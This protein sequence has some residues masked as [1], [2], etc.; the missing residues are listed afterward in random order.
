[1]QTM[2]HSI[3][4]IIIINDDVNVDIICEVIVC[5][6]QL[7]NANKIKIT[8]IKSNLLATAR[9]NFVFNNIFQFNFKVNK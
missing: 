3:I 9:N 2:Q 5:I 4:I 6:L 8:A 1:M 7:C